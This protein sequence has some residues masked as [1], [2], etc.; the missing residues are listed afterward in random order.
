MHYPSPLFSLYTF[1]GGP[2]SLGRANVIF[3]PQLAVRKMLY[4]YPQKLQTVW[5]AHINDPPTLL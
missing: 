2:M 4:A 3:A 1:R 5:L